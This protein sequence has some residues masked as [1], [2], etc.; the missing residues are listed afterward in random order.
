MNDDDLVRQMDAAIVQA[1]DMVARA[2]ALHTEAVVKLAVMELTKYNY[3][4]AI[5]RLRPGQ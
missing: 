5:G 2:S 1:K 3:L 4:V